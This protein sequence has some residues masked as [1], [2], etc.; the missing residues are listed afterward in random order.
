LQACIN[1]V[2]LAIIAD[3]IALDTG[4]ESSMHRKSALQLPMTMML[5]KELLS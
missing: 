2:E 1:A 5:G 3:S 4:F